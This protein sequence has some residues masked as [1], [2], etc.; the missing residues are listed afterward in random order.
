ME[1][2]SKL[3]KR[4]N[5]KFKNVDLLKQAL[6]H[7]SYINEHPDFKLGHNERLEFLGDAVLEII[8]TEFLYHAYPNQSEGEL[9]DWRASLVNANILSKVA[10]GLG[11]EDYLFLSR[12][13][14]KDKNTKARQIILANAIEAVIGAIYL[15][16]EIKLAKDFIEKEILSHLNRILDEGLV[17]DPKSLFQEK[18]QELFSITPHYEVLKEFGPDHEKI[19][20]VGLY[21]D[22]ELITKGSGTSKHEAQMD[23]AQKGLIKK[24]WQ[25]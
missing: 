17:H 23:A 8:V 10:Y 3:E 25:N 4:L 20:E 7:R 1:D 24:G 11:L 21:I 14:A 5:Y 13:E 19:F 2:F 9:T 18:A 12:G 6:V 22:Q 16:G 15:D